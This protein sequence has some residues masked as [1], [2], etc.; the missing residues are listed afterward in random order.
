MRFLLDLAVIL[1][2]MFIMSMAVVSAVA[3]NIGGIFD[4]LLRL[5]EGVL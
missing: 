2:V 5:I 1:A 4:G 3:V